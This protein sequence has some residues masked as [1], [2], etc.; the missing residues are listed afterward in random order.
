M[1]S[2]RRIVGEVKF[3]VTRFIFLHEG[4]R[5]KAKGISDLVIRKKGEGSLQVCIGKD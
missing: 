5:V 4:A 3:G 2:Y 1:I